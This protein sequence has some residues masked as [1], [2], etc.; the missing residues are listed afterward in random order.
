MGLRS[1]L[2][3]WLRAT[4]VKDKG[5][6][7][8]LPLVTR[9]EYKAYMGISS[10]TSDAAIDAL[11]PKVSELV[12]TICRRTFIDYVDD[13]KVEYSEGGTDAIE[14]SEYPVLSVSSLEY[15]T[16]FGATYTTLT[17][18]TNYV[19]S[20]ATNSIRPILMDTLPLDYYGY[21]PHGSNKVKIF[22]EAINGYIITYTAGYLEIPQDL[23][24]CILDILAYYLKNDSSVHTHKNV[25]PNTMQIE[26]LSNTHFPAHIKRILD[27]YT[28][29]YN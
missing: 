29:S 7:M 3:H 13:A 8:G 22:P 16:D 28:A 14:L 2:L 6:N 25:N 9:A 4:Y 11:I 10:T 21:A 23:K 20:K 18:Y 19:L 26:Y 12:K 17:E 5:I 1:R 15:S 27:L 24:L